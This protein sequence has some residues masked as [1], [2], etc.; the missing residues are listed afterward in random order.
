MKKRE[1]GLVLHYPQMSFYEEA[2]IAV[3]PELSK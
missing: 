2:V 3:L 1:E